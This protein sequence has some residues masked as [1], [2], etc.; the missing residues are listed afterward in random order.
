MYYQRTKRLRRFFLLAGLAVAGAAGIAAG[1]DDPG[2]SLA[3][4]SPAAGKPASGAVDHEA[5][6]KASQAD[7]ERARVAAAEVRRKKA[8]AE[9]EAALRGPKLVGD[10]VLRGRL[11][12]AAMVREGDTYAVPIGKDGRR[13]ILTLD[14]VV[15]E[16][17]DK[18]LAH[19][20]APMSAIVVM[21]PDGQILALAG[22]KHGPDAT[23][24]SGIPA[25]ELATSVWAPS[26]SIFK[27]VTAAALLQSG[28][29]A[30]QPVCFHGGLRSVTKTNLVDDPRRDNR[31]E[32]LG[33]GVSES[34]NALVAKLAH[35]YLDAAKI[36]KAARALGFGAPARFALEAEASRFTVPDDDLERAKFA[37]GFWSSELS[38]LDGALLTNVIATGG[39]RVTPRIVAEVVEA[40]GARKPVV[41]PKSERVLPKKVAEAIGAMMVRTTENGTGA[42]A[43][44]GRKPGTP[45]H[46]ITVAGKTG[47]LSQVKPSYLGFSWFVAY[48]P[49]DR[50]ELVVSVLLGNPEKWWIKAHTAAR[51][52][53]EKALAPRPRPQVAAD[54]KK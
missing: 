47:S 16:E 35:R 51:M 10:A 53:M 20:R 15:Q 36:S 50:P 9:L 38:A 14:P 12:L 1:G 43:F 25:F 40:G 19:A 29:R 7:A 33:I 52:L 30:D 54:T 28:V 11:D 8:D 22:R 17:A 26:A 4:G 27:L 24:D 6:A 37:A 3:A 49:A 41:A 46:G 5:A 34:N 32:T 48:A 42:R 45:L 31:C 39:L 18:L 21:K 13:A 23:R 2:P 44:R